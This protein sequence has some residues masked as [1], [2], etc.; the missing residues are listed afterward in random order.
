[1]TEEK[2]A[3][4]PPMTLKEFWESRE[5]VSRLEDGKPEHDLL[6]QLAGMPYEELSACATTAFDF[7]GELYA[8]TYR[9]ERYDVKIDTLYTKYVVVYVRSPE[10]AED[11]ALNLCDSG[12][13]D[14]E[15]N[16]FEGWDINAERSNEKFD[17]IGSEQYLEGN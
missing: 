7:L 8:Q 17:S 3:G 6:R 2:R 11:I 12:V 15:R 16:A 13:I 5:F 10:R 1:M 14:T 4:S 9:L